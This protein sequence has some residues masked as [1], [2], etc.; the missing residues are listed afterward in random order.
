MITAEE[1]LKR[2]E[3]VMKMHRLGYATRLIKKRCRIQVS[4]A[5]K[6]AKEL[7]VPWTGKPIK[8]VVQRA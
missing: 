2:L 8:E 3:L 4:D 7:G 6:L 1:R 5:V